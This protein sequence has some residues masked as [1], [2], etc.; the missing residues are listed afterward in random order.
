MAGPSG[1][2]KLRIENEY[3]SPEWGNVFNIKSEQGTYPPFAF[4]QLGSD[5]N[6]HLSVPFTDAKCNFHFKKA[7][8]GLASLY[9]IHFDDIFAKGIDLLIDL[10][11][12][13]RELTMEEQRAVDILND[14]L[15]EKGE[16]KRMTTSCT[17]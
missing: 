3:K 4:I 5:C 2:K 16:S 7:G 11:Q 8:L 12:K 14:F 6:A 17:Q 13:S 10:E 1:G 9:T 15:N